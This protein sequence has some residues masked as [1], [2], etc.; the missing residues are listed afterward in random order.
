MGGIEERMNPFTYV[1]ASKFVCVCGVG[2]SFFF[3]RDIKRDTL[4]VV[5]LVQPSAVYSFV[6]GKLLVL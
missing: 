1:C 2:S 5:Q 3:W 6:V 4:E